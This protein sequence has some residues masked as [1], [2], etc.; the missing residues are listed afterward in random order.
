MGGKKR[1]Y[2][3]RKGVVPGIYE[4]Y[5]ECRK[6][7]FRF[8]GADYRVFKTEEEAKAYLD[9][10]SDT[11][12]QCRESG[13]AAAFVDGSYSPVTKQYAY[14]IV[15]LHDGHRKLYSVKI[16]DQDPDHLACVRSELEGAAGAMRY[17]L[18]N[19]VE[20][21]DLYYDYQGIEMFCTGEWKAKK[22]TARKYKAFY[23]SAKESVNITFC[24]VKAHSGVRYNEM[25]D[26]LAKRAIGIRAKKSSLVSGNII[27]T[28]V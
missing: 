28:A 19:H 12:E 6:N 10:C 13:R 25:A 16:D 24:K 18:D 26:V 9:D 14:G 3:V 11:A 21:L 5:E 27:Q 2:A 7:V 22:E 4:D 20:N 23:D 8:S 17:C 15:I 1:Y